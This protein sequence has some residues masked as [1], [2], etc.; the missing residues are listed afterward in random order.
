M[1][2][3]NFKLSQIVK[4]AVIKSTFLTLLAFLTGLLVYDQIYQAE[5]KR[6]K[7]IQQEKLVAVNTEFSKEVSSIIKLTQLL[8]SNQV[9][10]NQR[11]SLS[12]TQRRTQIENYFLDFGIITGNISQ[13]RW[14]NSQATEIYRVNFSNTQ[15]KITPQ[16]ELQAKSARYYVT[17]G[18]KVEP[19]ATYVSKIDLNIEQG[20]VVFPIEPTIRVTFKTN[21]H[22]YLF[23]G[24]II[25]NFNLNYLF[26]RLRSISDKHSKVNILNQQGYW[27]L[28]PD[29]FNEF[30]FMFNNEKRS[31]GV[32]NPA[33]WQ[34]IK[35]KKPKHTPHYLDKNLY[36]YRPL[37]Y[38]S[39][40]ELHS[41]TSS[42]EHKVYLLINSDSILLSNAKSSALKYA[43]LCGFI[44]LLITI[45]YV[46]R[47]YKYQ[48]ELLKLSKQLKEEETELRAV[49]NTLSKTVKQQMQ[50][51][52]SLV[53]AQK[54]SSL[55]MLVAG[56]AHEMNTPIGGAI[57]S[58]SNAGMATE[59][60]NECVKTGLTKSQLDEGLNTIAQNISLARVNLDKSALLVKSFKRMAVDRNND[61]DVSF[62]ITKLIDDLL[63]TLSPQLKKSRVTLSTDYQ[64]K[65]KIT[66]RPGIISQILE[67]LIINAL[68]HGFKKQNHGSINISVQTEDSN[69][70]LIVVSDTGVGINE[71]VQN[72][73]FEPFYT[74]ARG[75]GNTGL[76]LYMV[77]QW[78]TK[79]LGG[80][81]TLNKTPT[82]DYTTQFI[83]KFAVTSK[84]KK[85]N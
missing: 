32:T 36:T 27:L 46:Y 40:R 25:I 30:G 55:G 43:L 61:D 21:S 66:S 65:G 15:G 51:Q 4:D 73:I 59:K 11:A 13:I 53:E 31:L 72:V 67:N 16:P 39:A 17:E 54:L 41:S 22:D 28:S 76:G 18:L 9:L 1:K 68:T 57:I 78:V 52:E 6:L 12:N 56:V 74:S 69:H 38:I 35:N 70:L 33:L 81:I 64:F 71:D 24:L 10:F 3:I 42:Q 2:T 19:P 5:L 80:S 34:R 60:L 44:L 48:L 84:N 50:L 37:N 75:K 79:V 47:D 82:G 63:I 49:N 85:P 26:S 29:R 23:D 20:E 58:I 77:H 7:A 14:L 8:A 62:E 83:I 45:A